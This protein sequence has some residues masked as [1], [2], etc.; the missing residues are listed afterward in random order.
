MLGL[1]LPALCRIQFGADCS[2]GGK[3][4]L[5]RARLRVQAGRSIVDWG[6]VQKKGVLEAPHYPCWLF[7]DEPGPI[8]NLFLVQ[9]LDQKTHGE[10]ATSFRTWSIQS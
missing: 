6:N 3:A 8:P 10:G 9:T 2:C 1:L 4:S 5:G 7:G